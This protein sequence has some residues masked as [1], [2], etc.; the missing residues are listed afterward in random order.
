MS[1][2]QNIKNASLSQGR[3]LD[4]ALPAWRLVLTRELADLWIGGRALSL[5]LI[6][7]ILLGIMAYI[8]SF[9]TALD[10]IPPMEA[11][12]E[13]LR[14]ALAVSAFMGLIIGADSL[15]GERDR[16]TLES[17]LLTPVNRRD[18]I[19]AK[20]LAGISTWPMAYI[21]AIPYLYVLAQGD[22]VLNLALLWGAITGTVLVVGYTGLGML[23]SFWSSSDKTSYFV[24][25]GIYALL[26]I[27]AELPGDTVES[28]GW[29]LQWINP[30]AAVNRFLS[31]HLVEYGAVA[32]FW[33]WLISSTLLAFLSVVI[34]LKYCGSNLHLEARVSNK[35]W[36]A[37]RRAVN[38]LVIAGLAVT[39]LLAS[40]AHA[41]QEDDGL[42]IS[43]GGG[44]KRVRMGEKVEINTVITNNTSA[45]STHLIVAM[46]I[47]NLDETGEAVDP[48]DWSPERTQYI[49]SLAAGET[50]DLEWIVNPILE[51]DFIMYLALI[52]EPSN[53]QAISHPVASSG[54]HLTVTP[55]TG[56][57]SRNILP[58]VIGEPV[59]LLAITYFVYRHRRQQIDLGGSA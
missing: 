1:S 40:P 53:T 39:S 47:I 33:T 14:H 8:Y 13:M 36:A 9:N 32:E 23:V 56:P 17:L 28:V 24:S 16:A 59:L 18:I 31:K 26:L 48:E 10:L 50:V 58:L 29:F 41:L 4:P 51:G 5:L 46:N 3:A 55:F 42:S 37:L 30:M 11:V 57:K 27:P 49:G 15:S 22:P 35:V 12:S 44:S 38:L 52:P 6:Y 45:A 7:S 54:I 20:L 19:V 2:L 25:L 21:V 34:L 43:I